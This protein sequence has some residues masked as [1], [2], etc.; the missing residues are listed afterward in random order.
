MNDDDIADGGS[1]GSYAS[2]PCFWHELDPSQGGLPAEPDAQ[3]ARDVARWRKAERIRLL[4]ARAALPLAVREAAAA[5]IAAHLD[6]VIGDVAGKVVSAYWPI[7]SELDL[8][9]WLATLIARGAV[10]ALPLVVEKAAPLR[11]RAWAP[12]VRMTR[13]FWNIP[14]PAEGD[15]L[16]P[17]ILISPVVGHDADCYRLGYGGGYFDRT[18]AVAGPGARAYGVG[19]AASRI[20][21]IYPQPHDIPMRAVVTETGVCQPSAR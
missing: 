8:R 19:L 4:D 2:P 5:A 18:L 14:V 11:F 7:R 20:A 16:T 12:G 13:G 17:D 1:G 3:Q 9:P 15:W 6:R 10:A 21:T